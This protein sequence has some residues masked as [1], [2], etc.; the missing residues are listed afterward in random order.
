MDAGE[1]YSNALNEYQSQLRELEI[2]KEK[3]IQESW[4]DLKMLGKGK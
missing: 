1:N 2:G 3:F 4:E